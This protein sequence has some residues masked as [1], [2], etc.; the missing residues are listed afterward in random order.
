MGSVKG[1]G[2]FEI[3]VLNRHGSREDLY[4]FSGLLTNKH[5][6]RVKP[7]EN[8]QIHTFKNAYSNEKGKDTVTG[9]E[10]AWS[11]RT[12]RGEI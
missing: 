7:Q 3:W 2:G 8:I 11:F 12:L 4:I 1:F 6:T 9:V 10:R 5:L